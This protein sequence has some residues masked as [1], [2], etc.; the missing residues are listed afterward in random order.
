MKPYPKPKKRKKKKIDWE[1][2]AVPKVF[3]KLSPYEYQK[4]KQRVHRLDGWRCINP[5][6]QEN[7]GR[8]ELHIHHT[9]PRS[10]QRL[11]TEENC[12]SICPIC[13]HY[14]EIKQLYLDFPKL[15]KE[16]RGELCRENPKT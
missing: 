12:S 4:L 6:C 11:D 2:F 8:G 1:G 9:T 16:R 13:H 10:V 15:I 7:Y 3:V 5:D 14:V